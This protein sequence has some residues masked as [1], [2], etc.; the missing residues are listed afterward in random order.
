[1]RPTTRCDH[2]TI[3]R[4]GNSHVTRCEHGVIHVSLGAVSLRLSEEQFQGVARLFEE[5]AEAL[6][7]PGA[8]E[9]PALLC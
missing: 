6:A 2:A 9:R 4:Q 3:A 1:M 7:G 5:A 8:N